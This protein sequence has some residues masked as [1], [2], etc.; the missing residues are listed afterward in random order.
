VHTT[1]DRRNQPFSP[2]RR[3]QKS[4]SGATTKIKYPFFFF[5]FKQKSKAK[6][7]SHHL[8]QYFIFLLILKENVDFKSFGI[9]CSTNLCHM[10]SNS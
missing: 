6:F 10:W 3:P 7:S 4:I 1:P 8:V 5:C 2:P 9:S